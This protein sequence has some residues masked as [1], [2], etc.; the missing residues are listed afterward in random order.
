MPR[1]RRTSELPVAKSVTSAPR[2]RMPSAMLNAICSHGPYPGGGVGHE[3]GART[4][5]LSPVRFITVEQEDAGF[6][7]GIGFAERAN[8][9]TGVLIE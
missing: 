6:D 3:I 8:V 7:D 2:L 5:S 9:R 4:A 1:G